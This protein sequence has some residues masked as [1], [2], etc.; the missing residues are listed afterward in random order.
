[1]ERREEAAMVPGG[2]SIPA[3]GTPGRGGS[4]AVAAREVRGHRGC[5]GTRRDSGSKDSGTGG[6]SSL[7]MSVPGVGARRDAATK[8]VGTGSRDTGY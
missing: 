1:M 7:G 2:A 5:R 4:V 8:G 3:A 6:C